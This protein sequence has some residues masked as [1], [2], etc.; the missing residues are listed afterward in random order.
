MATT[1]IV[2]LSAVRTPFG[3]FG[4]TLRDVSA[5]DLTVHAARAALERAGVAPGEVQHAIFGNVVQS[6]SDTVYFARHVALKSG[7]AIETPALTVN[8]LCGS[9]F[10]AIVNGAQEILLEEAEVCLVGGGESMS[11][12]PHVA[13]GIRWGTPLGKSPPLEDVLWEALTDSYVGLPMGQT[14]ENL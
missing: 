9:G 6:T 8:R 3:T 5:V 11:T 1:D 14:A 12:T 13:R 7:C 4:G 2:F 10:Q